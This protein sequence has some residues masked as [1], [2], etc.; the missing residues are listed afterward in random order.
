MKHLHAQDAIQLYW[1]TDAKA[2]KDLNDHLSP[3]RGN[4]P[5]VQMWVQAAEKEWA[6]LVGRNCL[7][8]GSGSLRLHGGHGAY[9]VMLQRRYQA[10]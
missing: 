1:P 2:I 4:D 6:G 3:S 10:E 8:T 5:S 9:V 7:D